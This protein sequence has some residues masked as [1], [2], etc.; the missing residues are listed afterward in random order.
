MA[1]SFGGLW[2]RITS[3]ENLFAAAAEAMQGKRRTGAAARYFARW[4]EECVRL[5]LALRDGSW[6]HG[7]YTYFTISDPKERVVA[8][9]T[10]RDRVAHHALVRVLEPLLDPTLVEDTFACRRGKG[11]HAAMARAREY[12]RRYP[13][14]LKCDIRKYFP[15]I[16]HAVLAAL[17]AGRVR[18]ATVRS[19]IGE[20]LAS[21]ADAEEQVWPGEDLLAVEVRRRGLPIGNLTSQFFANLYLDPLDRF[22]KQELRVPGYVRYV[23]DF[24]LFGED[25]AQVRAWGAQ[26]KAFVRGLELSIHPDKYRCGPTVGGVDFC[27]FVVFADGRI[28]LRGANVRRFT[29]RFRAQVWAVRRGRMELGELEERTRCWAAHASHAQSWRLRRSIL[30]R[31]QVHLGRTGQD[32]SW[33]AGRLVE[34]QREQPAVVEPERQRRDE[35]EQQHRFPRRQPLNRGAPQ[36]ATRQPDGPERD[37]ARPRRAVPRSEAPV[38]PACADGALASDGGASE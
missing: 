18:E 24:I 27:G 28:R 37:G 15:S 1:R 13:Y 9:A 26:V 33:A 35:R 11:T 17:L 30:G 29:R 7:P 5:R 25:R 20:I 8:A 23:D 22:I 4:E 3:L 19:M 2:E 32:Q 31:V 14:F 34:Q 36:G 38:R 10:F 6:R 21:H 12:A 16:P